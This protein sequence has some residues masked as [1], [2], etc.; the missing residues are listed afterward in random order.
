LSGGA[1]RVTDHYLKHWSRK[2]SC[3]LISSKFKGC[4]PKEKLNGYTVF[5]I[6]SQ[7]TVYFLAWKLYKKYFKGK[8]DV[9]I[10]Q[11]NTIPFFAPLYVREKLFLFFHQLC[12]E[13]WFYERRQPLASFG[14]LF[15]ATYLRLYRNLPA[16]VVSNSTKES[17]H[18]F[19][20]KRVYVVE[21]TT[22]L[23]PVSSMPKKNSNKLLYIGR[24]KASKR[25]EHALYALHELLKKDRNFELHIVGKGDTQYESFLVN[26]AKKLGIASR[27][28]FHGYVTEAEKTELL[29]ECGF[30][31]VTSVRE[32]W[33]L[34]ITEA[35]ARGTIP[36]VYNV[37]G[38]RDS[39]VNNVTGIMT[40]TNTPLELAEAIL[41]VKSKPQLRKRL[42]E[43]A[44]EHV[45][46]MPSWC[47]QADKFLNIMLHS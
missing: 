28:F 18:N 5:R 11:I 21:N 8:V 34:V 7:K 15:E 37:P 33:G 47:E 29:N 24:L 41:T 14:Y 46:K 30:L 39:V 23:S 22:E 35:Q 1:E 17:L 9:V 44:I 43:N 27:V 4:Q 20:F 6:G 38:L 25:V 2:N 10:E 45:K 42:A 3:Y 12:R 36:V 16:I 13:I 32:G 26:K 31:L 19:G 40:K